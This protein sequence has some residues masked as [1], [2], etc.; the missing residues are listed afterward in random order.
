[1][2]TVR[3]SATLDTRLDHLARKTNRS[4]SFYIKLALE[5]FLDEQEDYLL[6]QDTILKNNPKFSLHEVKQEL[7][8]ED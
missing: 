6:A 8:I 1:M 7:G 2:T 3:L 5:G 4:K